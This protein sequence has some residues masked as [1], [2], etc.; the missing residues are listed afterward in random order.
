MS[1]LMESF[2]GENNF[3][4]K[5][6]VWILQDAWNDLLG[7]IL[8]THCQLAK[9]EGDT[10]EI[11]CDHAIY[12]QEII[13]QKELIIKQIQE[14]IGFKNINI[15][16][17]KIGIPHFPERIREKNSEKEEML[18]ALEKKYS[19]PKKEAKVLKNNLS[20]STNSID[21]IPEN[22]DSGLKRLYEVLLKNSS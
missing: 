1:D 18:K 5:M 20:N 3:Q 12:A 17:T 8:T 6:Q 16:H 10:L 21:G 14:E 13:Q 9:V 11:I 15:L 4:N 22:L 19:N 7:D 2:L